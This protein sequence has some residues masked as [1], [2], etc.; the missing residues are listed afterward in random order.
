MLKLFREWE[1]EEYCTISTIMMYRDGT[2]EILG[3]YDEE[4]FLFDNRKE[5]HKFFIE[6]IKRNKL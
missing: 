3:D 2:G 5:L 1:C 6:E 4:I